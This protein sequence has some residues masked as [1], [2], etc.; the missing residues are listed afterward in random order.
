MTFRLKA[1]DI[2][3]ALRGLEFTVS[4]EILKRQ[5]HDLIRPIMPASKAIVIGGRSKWRDVLPYGQW[6]TADGTKFLFDRWYCALWERSPDGVTVP[7]KNIWVE[8]IEKEFW[9][10]DD[11]CTPWANDSQAGF[12]ALARCVRA[13]FDFGI[14]IE[15]TKTRAIK[16]AMLQAPTLT[17][18]VWNTKRHEP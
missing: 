2:Q 12:D 6:I 16:E 17:K 5:P 8:N 1:K 13:L 18:T 10:F 4:L 15:P 14:T 9:F 3:A 7:A 11:S